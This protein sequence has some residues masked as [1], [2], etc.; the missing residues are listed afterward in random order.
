MRAL[1]RAVVRSA[2][3]VV[4]DD[5]S[6]NQALTQ[7]V[8]AYLNDEARKDRP[9]TEACGAMSAGW[10]MECKRP[11]GHPHDSDK[12]HE[13]FDRRGYRRHWKGW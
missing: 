3:K 12:P 8:T 10:G 7:I 6:V 11:M 13:G 4:M 2:I 1:E 5:P 9:R